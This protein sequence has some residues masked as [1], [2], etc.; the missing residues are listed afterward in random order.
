[1]TPSKPSSRPIQDPQNSRGQ[2]SRG[3]TPVLAP[4]DLKRLVN[5]VLEATPG[6][7]WPEAPNGAR[8]TLLGLE[9]AIQQAYGAFKVELSFWTKSRGRETVTTA[10]KRELKAAARVA[11]KL[12]EQLRNLTPE[13]RWRIGALATDWAWHK[14]FKG[15]KSAS[16]FPKNLM[17]LGLEAALRRAQEHNEGLAPWDWDGVP[18]QDVEF[19]AF[20]A[21]GLADPSLE[22]WW[23]NQLQGLV[24]L[25]DRASQPVLRTETEGAIPASTAGPRELAGVRRK[26]SEEGILGGYPVLL[27]IRECEAI[28]QA[29]APKPDLVESLNSSSNTPRFGDLSCAPSN[30]EPTSNP[31]TSDSPTKSIDSAPHLKNLVSMMLTAVTGKENILDLLRDPFDKHKD[32]WIPPHSPD[33]YLWMTYRTAVLLMQDFLT[34]PDIKDV[35]CALTLARLQKQVTDMEDLVSR[36]P[37]QGSRFR[38]PGSRPLPPGRTILSGVVR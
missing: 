36:A 10:V 22:P 20:H 31:P 27:L 2:S 30:G 19:L 11:G 23:P 8:L 18:V 12:A 4:G 29:V 9:R 37:E 14:S 38:M 24:A 7:T 28:L 15:S 32:G 5:I 35:S 17:E 26:G 6:V 34:R 13:A 33:P 1:M 16:M 25:L 3:E 21:E